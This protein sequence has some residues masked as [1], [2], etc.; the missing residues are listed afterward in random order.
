MSHQKNYRLLVPLLLLAV[1]LTA[2]GN[3]TPTP[4]ITTYTP[5]CS[6]PNLIGHIN[7]ANS[8]PGPS[9]I[10][11]DGNCVYTLTQSDNAAIVDSITVHN[12]LPVI[13]N[14]ITIHGNN[15]VIDIQPA[16]GEP[17]FGHFYVESGGDLELYNLLL[18]NGSRQLGGSVI[19]MEGDFF[20][21]H[22]VFLNNLAYPADADSIARGGAIYNDS[23]RVRVID[24]SLFQENSAGWTMASGANLGGA[25]F[26]KNGTLL[27][28]TSSFLQNFAAGN[29]GA[30]YTVKNAANENGGLITINDSD[31][32]ENTAYQDGGAIVLL[33][34]TEGVFIATTRFRQNHAENYG[35]AIYAEGSELNDEHSEFRLNSAAFGGA[36]FSKRPGEGILSILNSDSST[37]IDNDASEIGGAIFSENTDL[38]LEASTFES[39]TASSCGAIR[40]GGHPG[41]DVVAGDLETLPRI[42]SDAQISG[43]YFSDNQATDTHGGAICHVMGDLSIQGSGFVRNSAPEYGGALILHDES[44]LSGSYFNSNAAKH[45]GG[46]F[47]GYPIPY[48]SGVYTYVSPTYMTFGTTLSGVGF[49]HNHAD[50]SGGGIHAHH[51]GQ[52]SVIKSVFDDNSA[53]SAGGGIYLEEGDMYIENSTFSGNTASR[54]GGLYNRGALTT[55]PVLEIRHSTFAYNVAIED[56]PGE[57]YNYRWGGGGLNI[58]GIVNLNN[59]L[60]TLNTNKDC[61]LNQSLTYTE[62]GNVDSDGTCGVFLTEPSP[63]IGPLTYNGGGTNTHALLPGS[64]LIDIL[65]D[66]AGL[67]DD[68]RGISRPQGADCDPGAYEFDPTDPP[69]PPP[70]LP[71]SDPTPTPEPDDS[72]T[73]RCDLFEEL[74]ISLVLLEIPSETMN[75][76]LYLKVGGGVPGLGVE[77]PD[78]AEPW[79]YSALLGPTESNVCS[80]QGFDD[81]LYCMFTMPLTAPGTAQDLYLYLNGC[82]DP[83]FYQPRVTIPK[84]QL[85]CTVDLDEA[86]CEAGGGDF[87]QVTDSETICVC[88]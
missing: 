15:A 83:I 80:L 20:A 14:Q 52:A 34:E 72:S 9:A 54:G 68:Q 78:D 57:P 18:K 87:Y 33:D 26:S 46:L 4:Q 51:A 35:G 88:P 82:D 22:T 74:A 58:N 40:N 77:V 70:P 43:G 76:P 1:Y 19:N 61:D 48:I 66:C 27:V 45:G 11:L 10:N 56:S 79:E 59:S 32:N 47:I 29:G 44:A 39:N 36:I 21:S 8:N 86:A 69:A 65:P 81:R 17:F 41:L 30:I 85:A 23:G 13:S 28:S 73:D 6:V 71:S 62:S 53:G 63:M 24:N 55:Y 25:I 42:E 5:G 49:I 37:Y 75:L 31:F 16:D 3:P 38:S 2:C 64:P 60:I 12:G 7:Q 84:P 67:A 50:S